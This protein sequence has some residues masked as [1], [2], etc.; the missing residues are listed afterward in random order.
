[1]PE[2]GMAARPEASFER[3]TCVD[4]S[5]MPFRERIVDQLAEV[6]LYADDILVMLSADANA[7]DLRWLEPNIRAVYDNVHALMK[8]LCD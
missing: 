4:W 1:M 2:H 3:F 6:M 7:T 8:S 5:R